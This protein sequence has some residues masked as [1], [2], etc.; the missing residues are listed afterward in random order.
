MWSVALVLGHSVPGSTHPTHASIGAKG[1]HVESAKRACQHDVADRREN[2]STFELCRSKKNLKFKTV[3]P[4]EI[5]LKRN[6]SE[7][8]TKVSKLSCFSENKTTGRETF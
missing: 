6:C 3:R 2:R 7:T 5:K 8:E 1:V 4:I